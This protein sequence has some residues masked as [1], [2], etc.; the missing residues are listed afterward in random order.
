MTMMMMRMRIMLKTC[1][2]SEEA[3]EEN[4]YTVL[5]SIVKVSRVVVVIILTIGY[6]DNIFFLQI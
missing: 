5:E 2:K 3:L 1:G 4:L 6:P